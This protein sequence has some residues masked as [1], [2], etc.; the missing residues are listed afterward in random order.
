MERLSF[1]TK[2]LLGYFVVMVVLAGGMTL[3]VRRFSTAVVEQI[4]RLRAAEQQITVVERLRWHSEVMISDGR[5]YLLS[6]EPVLLAELKQSAVELDEELDELYTHGGPFIDEVEQAAT[7]FRRAQADLLI[8]RQGSEDTQ[9]LVN[10]F[11][12]EL[13]PL[14]QELDRALKRLVDYR[15]AA[16]ADFYESAQ[17][18]RAH[19]ELSLSVLR[20]SLVLASLVMAWYFA[21]RLGRSYRHEQRAKEAADRALAARDEIMG[22]VAH[23]LRNPL[24]AITLKATL[25]QKIAGS[26]QVR[27]HAESISNVA[28][29]MEVLIK[30][31]LDVTTMDAG[32]FT[33]SPAPCAVQELLRETNAMFDPLASSKQIHFECEQS[34]PGLMVRAEY[35]RV[36]QVLSNLVGN[37]LKFTPPGGYVTVTADREKAMVRFAII[38]SGPGIPRESLSRVFDRFWRKEQQE[39]KG[40][41]LGLFIAKSVVEAHGGRIWVDSDL[42]RGAKFYFTLPLVDESQ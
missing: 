13:L 29:R 2:A 11:E 23:D 17:K 40:T 5:G 25:L 10:R 15:Q 16:L 39:S 30:R 27:A 20:G 31:M 21:K 34:E 6:G 41:G 22:I 12:T 3:S 32:N 7:K 9:S 18:Q 19:L 1:Q 26:E 14:R 8:A 33:V 38:D 42:G 4:D 28:M 24:G 37:A 35:D 36:L